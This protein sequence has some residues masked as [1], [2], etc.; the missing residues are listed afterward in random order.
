MFLADSAQSQRVVF[1]TASVVVQERSE[2][3]AVLWLGTI[4]RIRITFGSTLA[5]LKVR[6][7]RNRTC[8]LA[9]IALVRPWQMTHLSPV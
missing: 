4:Q 6:L 7:G 9:Y 5:D 8:P 3:V 1:R 2:Q